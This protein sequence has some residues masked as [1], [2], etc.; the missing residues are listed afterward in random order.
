[1]PFVGCSSGNSSSVEVSSEEL[2][3][4]LYMTSGETGSL[5]P[6]SN[7]NEYVITLYNVPSEMRWITD[8]PARKSGVDTTSNFIEKVWPENFEVTAPNGI[9]KFLSETEN[10]G[11]FLTLKETTYDCDRRT[12][13]FTANLIRSTFE[14]GDPRLEATF[15]FDYPSIVI[16]NNGDGFNFVVHSETATMESSGQGNTYTI[17]QNDIDDEVLWA[18]S[19]PSTLSDISTMEKLAND[20][21]AM[22]SAVPPNAFMFGITDSGEMKSCS[23]TLDSMEYLPGST[24]IAYSASTP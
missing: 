9:L 18:S 6:T 13:R 16:L 23:I 8:R 2:S 4:R 3:T 12:L 15:E 5:E 11:L 24:T 21:D 1:M 10:D 22:F 14:D 20:W 17:V 7:D 19:A